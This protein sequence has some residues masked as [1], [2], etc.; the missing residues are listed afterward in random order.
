V[1]LSAIGA[2]IG[3]DATVAAIEVGSPAAQAGIQ[4]GERVV[5][6]SFIEPGKQEAAADAGLELSAKSPSWPYVVSVL[7]QVREGTKLAIEVESMGSHFEP[8]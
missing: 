1:S 4:P 6:V 5:R 2:A 7:Q 8:S 3:V